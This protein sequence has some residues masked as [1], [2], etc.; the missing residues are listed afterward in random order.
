MSEVQNVPNWDDNLDTIGGRLGT[1]NKTSGKLLTVTL[2]KLNQFQGSGNY[3]ANSDSAVDVIQAEIAA[4]TSAADSKT[5][6]NAFLDKP[7]K[8]KATSDVKISV[9]VGDT[10]NRVDYSK[11]DSDKNIREHFSTDGTEG[12]TRMSGNTNSIF[13]TVATEAQAKEM[14]T[15]VFIKDVTF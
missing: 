3:E 14:K 15:D 10:N 9:N 13:C 4:G 1:V 2:N 5:L 12:N 6:F 8:L 7:T 11:V